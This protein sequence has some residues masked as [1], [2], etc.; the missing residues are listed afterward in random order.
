MPVSASSKSQSPFGGWPRSQR[1]V[2][3]M[4]RKLRS[5][6]AVVLVSC[7]GGLVALGVL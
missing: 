5:S 6:A 7:R 3:T 1:T 2:G 4:C